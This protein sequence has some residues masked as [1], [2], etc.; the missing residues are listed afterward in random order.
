MQY[1]IL[2]ILSSSAISLILKFSES[3]GYNRNTVTTSNYVSAFTVSI[4]LSL[5]SSG[6]VFISG[7]NEVLYLGLFTGVMYYLGFIFIQK[8]IK[9]NGVGITGAISKTGIILPV[10]LSM[11]FWKEIPSV[12]QGTGVVISL[13]AIF[14]LNLDASDLKSFKGLKITLLLL[15]LISG[16][17]EFTTKIFEKYFEMQYKPLYMSVI[18]FTAFLISLTFTIRSV[19]HGNKISVKEI[20]T[21]LSAGIPNMAATYFLIES[22]KYYKASVAFPIYSSGTIL[23][24]NLGGY[25]IFGEKLSK[26]DMTAV[27]MIIIAIVMM[28]M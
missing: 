26:K 17:A 13:T 24:I 12:L 7:L 11:I 14:I 22:L 21:G 15:F 20:A 3:R 8:S 19:R 10:I 2:A 16:T 4:I 6:T 5:S 27:V 18:F 28:N 1:I 9:E 25:F 23:I